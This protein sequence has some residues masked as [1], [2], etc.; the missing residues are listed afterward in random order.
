MPISEFRKKLD[1]LSSV[2]SKFWIFQNIVQPFTS[3]N[4]PL[5]AEE[6]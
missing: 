1:W 3:I 6:Y 5:L 4:L 2:C